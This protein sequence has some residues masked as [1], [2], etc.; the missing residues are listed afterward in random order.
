MATEEQ[1]E[2]S[3]AVGCGD[4]TLV[5]PIEIWTLILNLIAHPSDVAVMARICRAL[6]YEAEIVLY[7]EVLLGPDVE[8]LLCFYRALSRCWRRAASV[9]ALEIQIVSE[10]EA[11]DALI[12][13]AVAKIL[14]LVKQY[15]PSLKINVIGDDLMRRC[16]EADVLNV[17]LPALRRLDTNFPAH[18]AF[19][20]CI[21]RNAQ[22]EELQHDTIFP[23]LEWNTPDAFPHIELPSLRKLTCRDRLLSH[24]APPPRLTHLYMP[25]YLLHDLPTIARLFGASLTSL[26][27]ALPKMMLG[28][29]GPRWSF[30]D[31]SANFPRLRYLRMDEYQSIAKLSGRGF[32]FEAEPRLQTINGAAKLTFVWVAMWTPDRE[33][34]ALAF[35]QTTVTPKAED[36]LKLWA[37]YLR[38]IVFWVDGLYEQTFASFTLA[39]GGEVT[40]GREADPTDQF[41]RDV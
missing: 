24:L 19:L 11:S 30:D 31:I 8:N 33:S 10:T 28:R 7:R 21:R 37:P 5:F 4:T 17:H 13:D 20:R 36:L 26:R 38:R 15:M 18:G 39:P 22:I 25:A 14:G 32:D 35:V 12:P 1:L 40:V 41:L 23:H 16:L 29:P 6:R 3:A 9:R 27:L 34:T 2:V